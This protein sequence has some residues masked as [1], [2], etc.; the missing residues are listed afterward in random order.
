MTVLVNNDPTVEGP[1]FTEQS[2]TDL[3]GQGGG[4]LS[5]LHEPTH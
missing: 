4:Y 1:I 2:I 3:A 5:L